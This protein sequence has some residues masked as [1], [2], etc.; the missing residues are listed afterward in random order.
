MAFSDMIVGVSKEK[1]RQT[2]NKLLNECFIIKQ[3]KDTVSDYTLILNNKDLFR[4]FFDLLGYEIIINEKDG[5]IALNNPFGT[6]RIHLRKIDSILLLI[7]RLL[8]IEKKRQISDINEVIIT[9]DEI[10]DKYN[11]LKLGNR[12][13]K[14]TI[15]SSLGLFKRYHLLSNLDKDMSDPNTRIKI[16]PSILFAVT[17]ESI[18]AIYDT[19]KEKLGKYAS[20]G[21]TDDAADVAEDEN[22]DEN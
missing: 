1:F 15:R 14:T 2:T 7:V 6:G 4:D 21:D 18:D 8:Y 13:D 16:W 9:A 10:Y 3:S 22:Y 5:V 17:V 20:G 11:M 12:L 19:A